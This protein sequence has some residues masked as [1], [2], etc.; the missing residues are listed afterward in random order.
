MPMSSARFAGCADA[1]TA[2]NAI[3]NSR[4]VISQR[5]R[6]NDRASSRVG[7]LIDATDRAVIA[8]AV[9]DGFDELVVECRLGADEQDAAIAAGHKCMQL[10]LRVLSREFRGSFCSAFFCTRAITGDE[11]KNERQSCDSFHRKSSGEY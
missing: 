6:G 2:R 5:Q 8:G 3:R 1:D 4:M 9:L 7:E 10:V 11:R